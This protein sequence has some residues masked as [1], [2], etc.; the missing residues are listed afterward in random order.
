MTATL[1][2]ASECPSCGGVH[3]DAPAWWPVCP[4][5]GHWLTYTLRRTEDG[6]V[7]GCLA[8]GCTHTHTQTERITMTTDQAAG[9]ALAL[10]DGQGYWDER[11]LA[12]LQ[13]LGIKDVTRADLQ[14]FL[15]YCQRT[16]LDPFSRQIYMIARRT[17][18]K[19]LD[20][21]G[22]LVDQWVSKQTIQ[23]GIDGLR[24]IA[25]RAAERDGVRLSY[26]KPVWYDGDGNE[27]PVWVRPEPPAAAAINVY[28]DRDVFPGIAR[29]DSFAAK[30]QAGQPM[31]QWATMPDH[32]IAKCAEAQALR[33]AFPHDLEGLHITDEGG[34]TEHVPIAHRAERPGPVYN[35]TALPPV[36]GPRNRWPGQPP[37]SLTAAI[38]AEFDRIGLEDPQERDTYLEKLANADPGAPLTTR[39]LAFVLDSLKECEDLAALVDLCA[40][41][42]S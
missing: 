3:G 38:G 30:T 9:A 17:K 42:A 5:H 2:R 39:D 8:R 40:V 16:G 23:V 22:R 18:E 32:M 31:A 20:E 34:R 25:R 13:Q 10:R 14:V 27:Y 37:G 41:E 6:Y 19:V 21:Q 4:R 26:G 36:E 11:Q 12:A 28:R 33:K 15:H 35:D 24:V 1:A 7:Y 29:F